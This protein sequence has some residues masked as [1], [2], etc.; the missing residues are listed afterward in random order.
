MSGGEETHEDTPEDVLKLPSGSNTGNLEDKRSVVVEQVVNLL[1]E[2][3]VLAHANVL[4]HLERDNLGERLAL[5]DVSV[6][7]AEDST[8]VLG[9]AVLSESVGSKLGLVLTE[10]NCKRQIKE[11]NASNLALQGLEGVRDG[12]DVPPVTSHP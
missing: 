12:R 11:S 9:N 8:L 1:E 6:V 10:S 4:G 7:G 3:R 5:G 2:G